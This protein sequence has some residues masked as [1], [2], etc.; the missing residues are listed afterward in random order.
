MSLRSKDSSA[1]TYGG[2]GTL[3]PNGIQLLGAFPESWSQKADLGLALRLAARRCQGWGEGDTD[4]TSI[5]SLSATRGSS[6]S[7][8]MVYLLLCAERGGGMPLPWPGLDH[9]YQATQHV[10][11]W[12]ELMLDPG[13]S[14]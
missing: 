7:H 2:G 9:H 6:L 12:E 1:V 14:Y 5:S 8:A 10:P 3:P 13:G 4:S 11:I